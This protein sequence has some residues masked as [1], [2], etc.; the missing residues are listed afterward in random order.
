MIL[1]L[2]CVNGSRY[3]EYSRFPGA[4]L[5]FQ[6]VFFKYFFFNAELSHS[7]VFLGGGVS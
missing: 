3:V 1:F 4:L 2:S 5:E 7:V 6:G